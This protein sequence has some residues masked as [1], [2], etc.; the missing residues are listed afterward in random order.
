MLNTSYSLLI[1][2]GGCRVAS[3]SVYMKLFITEIYTV[4][5]L[6]VMIYKGDTYKYSPDG[7]QASIHSGSETL[8][9]ETLVRM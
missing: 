8:F 7:G 9:L 5:S 2:Q 4:L 6:L 1:E 3:H